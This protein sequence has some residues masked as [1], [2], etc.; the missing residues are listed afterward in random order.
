LDINL[1]ASAMQ[2]ERQFVDVTDR[3]LIIE[4]PASFVNH[5]VEVIALTL[6]EEPAAPQH[7]RRPH[8]D[9]AGKGKILGDLVAPI[10]ADDDWECVGRNA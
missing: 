6:D 9:I 8:P 5:R 4:L 1:E 7:R 3:R 10:V 2:V